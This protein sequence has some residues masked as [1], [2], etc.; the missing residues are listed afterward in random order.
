MQPRENV[1]RARLQK[2][3]APTDHL[4]DGLALMLCEALLHVLV[5]QRII[6]KQRAMEAIE[7]VAELT[8]ET[9]ALGKSTGSAT[10]RRRSAVLETMQ[11]SFAVS[12]RPKR[13]IGRRDGTNVRHRHG[14]RGSVRSPPSPERA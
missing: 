10:D 3:L 7:T 4:H 13:I 6:S 1:T 11:A 14:V 8:R 12:D 5:E 2:K 9:A